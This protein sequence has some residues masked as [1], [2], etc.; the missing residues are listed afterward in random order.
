LIF[1]Y[2]KETASFLTLGFTKTTQARKGCLMTLSTIC[3]ALAAS[4]F[5]SSLLSLTVELLPLI[6]QAGQA[7]WN[8]QT[9]SITPAATYAFE[10]ELERRLDEVGRAILQAVFNRLEPE[11]PEQ[12]APSLDFDGNVYRCRGRSPRRE[13]IGTRFGTIAL[14]RTRYEPCDAD[15][16]L[17]SIF[18][19][20]MRLGIISGK[21]TLGLADRLGQWTAQHTQETVHRMLQE[22]HQ[23]SWS[24]TTIRKIMADLSADL[25]PLTHGAQVELLLKLLQQAHD[26]TGPHRPVLTA[27]R[28]GIF[29][30][31]RKDTK[32]REA[33]TATVAVL[34]RSGRRLG[35]VYLGHMPEPGQ[36]TLSQQL[37][38]LL[39]AVLNDWQ[40]PLPRL[41]YVTDGGHHPSEYFAKVLEPMLHPRTGKPLPWEWVVDYYHACLY[42][43]KLAEVLFGKETKEAAS[44]AA[45]MRRWLKNK[46]SGLLRVLHSAAAHAWRLEFT[47]AE[48][49]AYDDAYQY[50][51]TRRGFMDYWSCRQRG[52]AI[53]SGITEAACKTLFTQ[54]FKQSGMK[55]SLEGGQVVVDLRVIW[56]SKLWR[57]VFATYVSPQAEGRTKDTAETNSFKMAA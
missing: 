52:L 42:V 5:A 9:G 29:V 37:S 56:I 4:P 43:T 17:P 23:V 11:E 54:R 41:Q 1:W 39:R 40:G 18:P 19:L 57:T 6:A 20:E 14:E 44:W 8:F 21:A 47:P 13:G 46:K 26:S 16:G 53:G 51:Q 49:K 50:L 25:A 15:L 30:P 2:C 35:T 31:L 22:E 48:Q 36:G 24:V 12:A 3:T 10:V 28:D 45:K 27:G 33:A 55:W 34:D 7:I 38:A 32:Y